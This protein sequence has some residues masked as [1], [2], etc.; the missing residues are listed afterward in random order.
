[1]INDPLGSPIRYL[2]QIDDKLRRLAAMYSVACEAKENGV[3]ARVEPIKDKI[4]QLRAYQDKAN[5]V[6][7]HMHPF[8][9]QTNRN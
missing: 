5:Y 7:L 8:A 3:P 1:M 6:L 9:N 2:K 4:V